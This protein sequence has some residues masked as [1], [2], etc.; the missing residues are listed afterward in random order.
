MP[1]PYAPPATLA[2]P[3]AVVDDPTRK[4]ARVS[5][6]QAWLALRLAESIFADALGMALHGLEYWKNLTL[7][8]LPGELFFYLGL[9]WLVIALQ[10][11]GP[12]PHA[13]AL[14]IS[15]LWCVRSA[16][17][18]VSGLGERVSSGEPRIYLPGLIVSG[19][20]IVLTVWLVSSL[21]LHAKTRAYLQSGGPLAPPVTPEPVTVLQGLL[22]WEVAQ[23]LPLD[24]DLW[25]FPVEP[26]D[27]PVL[28]LLAF[29]GLWYAVGLLL[30]VAL[31]RRGPA[32]HVLA[33][34]LAGVFALPKPFALLLAFG[35]AESLSEFFASSACAR[36]VL[37][38]VAL[39]VALA[40]ALRFHAGTRAYLRSR[41]A[42]AWH[43]L[44]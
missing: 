36:G 23:Q 28:L 30:F 5:L 24:A 42:P 25:R 29:T 8:D 1:N 19:I 41:A 11:R 40:F 3:V 31:L 34:I 4:P 20:S 6:L 26:A 22:V 15:G 32:P 37:A 14:V 17:F 39:L 16:T 33:P 7:W 38:D 9:S 18:F 13:V 10:R 12:R 27:G 35:S 21:F 44:A 43:S 2:R